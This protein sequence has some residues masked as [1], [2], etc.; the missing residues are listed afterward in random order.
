MRSMLFTKMVQL[1]VTFFDSNKTGELMNRLSSD[2]TVVKDC[3]S[4]NISMG[5]RAMAE[6]VVSIGFLFFTSW[7]LTLV[8]MAVVRAIIPLLLKLGSIV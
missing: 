8:M 1:D 5:L 4:V 6:I 7:R 2:T 3:L